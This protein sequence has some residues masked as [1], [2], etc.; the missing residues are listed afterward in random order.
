MRGRLVG[1]W[2]AVLALWVGEVVPAAAWGFCTSRA[3]G[4]TTADHAGDL[5]H[6]HIAYASQAR[7]FAGLLTSMVSLASH[8]PV[9]T[10][11]SIHVIVAEVDVQVARDL[12]ECFNFRVSYLPVAP[13]VLIHEFQPLPF[14]LAFYG[15]PLAFYWTRIYLHRYL[16]ASASRVL[17]LDHDTIVK[18]D[19]TKLY[20]MQMR[21]PIAGAPELVLP[22]LVR[23]MTFRDHIRECERSARFV[24][25]LDDA[26]FN[27]GVLLLDLD[28]WRS[29]NLGQLV[30]DWA[31]RSDGCF[32]DQ[33]A[34]NLAFQGNVDFLDW[35]WNA[36][37]NGSTRTP[38]QCVQQVKIF[39]WN[40]YPLP[41]YWQVGRNISFNKDDHVW[42][43]YAVRQCRAAPWAQD[44]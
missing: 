14:P 32:L 22:H 31:V 9:G 40:S 21:G 26:T 16:P 13:M 33:L 5:R 1:C 30:A 8:L 43:P 44:R 36:R 18:D 11:C 24:Q 2:L 6:T 39:H 10:R 29:E 35:R 42:R 28:R 19:V 34:L 27:T 23:P 4:L 7:H 3:P 37:F 12:V 20:R 25:R 17:W 15:M 38:P 41:K